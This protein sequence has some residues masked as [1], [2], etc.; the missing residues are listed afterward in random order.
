MN[1]RCSKPGIRRSLT[2]GSLLLYSATAMPCVNPTAFGTVAA[3]TTGTAVTISTCTFQSE[4]NTITGVVAGATYQIT[5]SCGGYVTVRR[6]TP[7]GVI[8][9]QGNAPLSFTAPGAGTYYIHY[10]TNAACGTASTCCTTAI[11]CTSCGGGGGGGGCTNLTA[12]GSI[13]ALVV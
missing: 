10:T 9:A 5:S 11:T 8:A 6:T 13:A 7:G 1:H 4:Y 2:L 12:F 3:P